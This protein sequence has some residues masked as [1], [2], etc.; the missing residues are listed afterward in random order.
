M[1]HFN[2]KLD[3]LSAWL[4]KAFLGWLS[5]KR[6]RRRKGKDLPADHMSSIEQTSVLE[7][8]IATF[9]RCGPG[10]MSTWCCYTLR[11]AA[12]QKKGHCLAHTGE[13]EQ[14]SLGKSERKG[15]IG[16]D[17][18]KVAKKLEWGD[19]LPT[20]VK[21]QCKRKDPW[22]VESWSLCQDHVCLQRLKADCIFVKEYEHEWTQTFA[23]YSLISSLCLLQSRVVAF[24]SCYELVLIAC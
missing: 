13:L 20:V 9:G 24:D 3:Y 5:M 6:E 8:S 11:L 17:A 22:A 16:P 10:L 12:L 15:P 23:L 18:F 19:L 4:F 1:C 7:D 2:S 14:Y 21:E